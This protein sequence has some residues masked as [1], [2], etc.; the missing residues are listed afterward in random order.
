[1]SVFTTED[2]RFSVFS[3]D[4]YTNQI[5]TEEQLAAN[6]RAHKKKTRCSSPKLKSKEWN[7]SLI[8]FQYL[9]DVTCGMFPRPPPT[10]PT[11]DR[12]PWPATTAH[13]VLPARQPGTSCACISLSCLFHSSLVPYRHIIGIGPIFIRL[14]VTYLIVHIIDGFWSFIYIDTEL[15]NSPI[16]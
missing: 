16:N 5:Y 7:N 2:K 1:M 8:T 13:L 3:G 10:V 12:A 4:H 11:I 9:P 6:K 14:V 15:D